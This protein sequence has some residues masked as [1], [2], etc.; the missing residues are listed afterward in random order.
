M[1]RKVVER[2]ADIA[3][4]LTHLQIKHFD[5]P[6]ALSEILKHEKQSYALFK[7]FFCHPS[8]F[9]VSIIKAML[10][11][12]HRLEASGPLRFSNKQNRHFFTPIGIASETQGDTEFAPFFATHLMCCQPAIRR[13]KCKKG[14]FVEIPPVFLGKS[15]KNFSHTLLFGFDHHGICW[16][17]F[18]MPSVF[19]Y[20]VPICPFNMKEQFIET[21]AHTLQNDWT[22][23]VPVRHSL[24]GTPNSFSNHVRFSASIAPVTVSL[25]SFID[26]SQITK[27]RSTLGLVMT[28][29]RF[30]NRAVGL[31]L[32]WPS[33][34]TLCLIL[35]ESVDWVNFREP[36][37]LDAKCL[38]MSSWLREEWVSIKAKTINQSW[39]VRLSQVFLVVF[40]ADVGHPS[41]AHFPLGQVYKHM[42][43][44]HLEAF[45]CV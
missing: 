43:L 26:L 34:L 42:V 1:A 30:E 28:W 37:G 3:I 8:L 19:L 22:Q 21:R 11:W 16:C 12:W 6:A 10:C 9:V 44:V 41:L 29:G 38:T 14:Q 36:S 2:Q 18:S 17:G 39:R 23:D 13:C 27:A 4:L 15:G 25:F 24:S 40:L 31:E 32:T 33:R 20:L 7:Y 45:E 5:P 35:W